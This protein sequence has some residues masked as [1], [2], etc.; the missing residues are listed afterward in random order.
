MISNPFKIKEFTGKHMLAVL[1]L[2]FGTIITVNL[3]LAYFSVTN[4]TGL[5]VKNSYVASQHFNEKLDA[6]A[7]QKQ[8][9]WKSLLVVDSKAVSFTIKDASGKAITGLSVKVK[10]GH[11]V[12]DKFD[13]IQQMAEVTAGTYVSAAPEKPGIWDFD[14]RA[15]A[16]DGTR[17]RQDFRKEIKPENG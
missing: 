17:Y 8:L 2:F 7:R 5:V 13:H 11:P 6:A 4:W 15:V 3:A 10:I 12:A 16:A 14:V 9:G 1:F